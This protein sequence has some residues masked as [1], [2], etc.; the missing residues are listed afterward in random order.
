MQ[1]IAINNIAKAI[2]ACMLWSTAFAGIKIGLQYTKPLSFAGIRFMLSGVLLMFFAG[3]PG[4]YFKTV[5]VNFRLIVVLSFVQTFLVY[6]LFY[7]GITFVD[8]ALAAIIIGSSPLVTAIAA[9]FLMDHDKM[10]MKK[11]AALVFGIV[12]MIIITVSHKP[13]VMTGLKEVAGILILLMSTASGSIGNVLVAK[14]RQ[15]VKPMIFSS[16]QLFLGGF[17]LLLF[18]IPVEGVPKLIRV[19]EYYVALGWLAFL[20]A[21]AF[22]L[23]FNLLKKPEI[24]VSELNV[25]KFIIPLFGAIFSWI[26]LPEEQPEI[27]AITGM[28]LVAFSIVLYQYFAD[29]KGRKLQR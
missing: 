23:W 5:F 10:T 26:L 17:G 14:Y 21:A 20:S 29:E 15:V 27:F 1:K 19:K 3:R 6:G 18:S 28:I 13:W 25:W 11:T 2:I 16:A 7:T 8:G 9:H 24:K 12:G 4:N 22:A